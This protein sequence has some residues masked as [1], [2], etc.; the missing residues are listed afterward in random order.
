MKRKTGYA[1]LTS[2]LLT[3]FTGNIAMAS[4]RK[5]PTLAAA[6]DRAIA[7]VQ[8]NDAT[9]LYPRA[10]AVDAEWNGRDHQWQI[11]VESIDPLERARGAYYSDVAV[12]PV[13]GE[14]TLIRTGG[15]S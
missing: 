12:D 1:L 2:A 8:D 9:G 5:A 13:T 14:V 11:R 4:E 15:G 10:Y 3:L 6:T 7:Y